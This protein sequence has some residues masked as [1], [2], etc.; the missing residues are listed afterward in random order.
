MHVCACTRQRAV[1]R[2]HALL[3]AAL[4]RR[5]S[6]ACC[7]PCPA[8][9]PEQL[10]PTVDGAGT[11]GR[12]VFMGVDVHGRGSYGAAGA[13]AHLGTPAALCA[14]MHACCVRTC[15]CC[16]RVRALVAAAAAAA[17]PAAGGGGWG[18]SR[19]LAAASQAGLSAAL[20]A[21]GWV[22]ENLQQQRFEELQ[23]RWW[24]K[25]RAH[26]R[27]Q[28]S[29]SGWHVLAPAAAGPLVV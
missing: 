18:A 26:A 20:F 28:V 9:T 25:A 24:H 3:T 11:R 6:F 10:A 22:F 4:P 15:G 5:C 7:A 1:R 19:A 17:L 14:V 8:W 27:Q 16:E 29:V 12:S 23:Q 13:C 2:L 21:P